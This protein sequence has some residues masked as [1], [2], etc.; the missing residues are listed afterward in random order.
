[1]VQGDL[2]IPF[3]YAKILEYGE[4]AFPTAA[5]REKD[6]YMKNQFIKGL[7]SENI[8]NQIRIEDITNRT[9][10]DVK[11]LARKYENTFS[12]LV[13]KPVFSPTLTSN[14]PRPRDSS[15]NKV[16]FEQSKMH[17]PIKVSF[18]TNGPFFLKFC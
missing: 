6:S 10:E 16:S 5:D 3:Y 9:L 11:E 7:R 12:N 15:V 13:E 8:R 2:T 17:Q 4:N 1:L 14:A 18:L